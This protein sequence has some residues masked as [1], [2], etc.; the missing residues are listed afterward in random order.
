MIM[1]FEGALQQQ[2]H[3]QN[4]RISSSQK[5]RGD[6][7][8]KRSSSSRMPTRSIGSIISRRTANR[9]TANRRLANRR[10]ANQLTVLHPNSGQ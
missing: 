1:L 10:T 3:G 2:K 6:R 7:T 9:R 8:L 5:R 4:R